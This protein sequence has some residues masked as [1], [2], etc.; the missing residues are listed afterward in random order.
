M[1]N[2]IIYQFIYLFIHSL[3]PYS[4]LRLVHSRF[5]IEFFTE[6]DLVFPL[7]VFGN[8]SLPSGHPVGASVFFLLFL[9]LVSCPVFF[10]Q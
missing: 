8:P 6:I 5:E 10:F 7:S 3:T 4:V 2:Y 1:G 9:S